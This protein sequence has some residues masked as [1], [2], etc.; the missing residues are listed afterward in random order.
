MFADI[1]SIQDFSYDMGQIQSQ[2]YIDTDIQLSVNATVCNSH[3]AGTP[4]CYGRANFQMLLYLC[5]SETFLSSGEAASSY[6]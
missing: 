4:F 6:W 1:I 2:V 3:H 5:L